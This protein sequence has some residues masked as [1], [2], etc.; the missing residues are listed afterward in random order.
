MTLFLA[1][2]IAAITGTL[3]WGLRL[4]IPGLLAS[5]FSA[6]L[7]RIGLYLIWL[8]AV[9]AGVNK[10]LEIAEGY[11]TGVPSDLIAI[12]TM[13]GLINAMNIIASAYLFKLTLKIDSVKLLS[14]KA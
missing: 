6:V 4:V 5:A 14:S 8:F 9:T 11:L 2:F 3:S 10:L 1:P 7:V 13:T 12:M